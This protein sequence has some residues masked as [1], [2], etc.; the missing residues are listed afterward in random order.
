VKRSIFNSIFVITILSR[1]KKSKH[2]VG[3]EL[4]VKKFEA[5]TGSQRFILKTAILIKRN[6]VLKF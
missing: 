4:E 5:V 3:F 1:A 2:F 6:V